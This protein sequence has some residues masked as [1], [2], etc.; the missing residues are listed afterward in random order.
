MASNYTRVYAAS[1]TTDAWP[2]A[3]AVSADFAMR[4]M[5]R[6][7]VQNAGQHAINATRRGRSSQA[8][9]RGNRVPEV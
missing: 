6:S 4:V 9:R 7:I 5:A 8:A 1:L 2:C 3:G